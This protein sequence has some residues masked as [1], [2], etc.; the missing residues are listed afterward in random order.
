MLPPLTG[1]TAPFNFLETKHPRKKN[2]PP[3]AKTIAAAR[4]RRRDVAAPAVRRSALSRK[5]KAPKPGRIDHRRRQRNWTRGRGIVREGGRG[6]RDHLPE[7]TWRRRGN[8][9]PR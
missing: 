6:C 4:P 8:A 5:R 1:V 3:A 2:P 7:R 9:A